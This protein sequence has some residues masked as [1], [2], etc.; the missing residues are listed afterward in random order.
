MKIKWLGHSSFLVTSEEGTKIVTDPYSVGGGISYAPINQ[1]ADVVTISHNH[2]DHNN[3]RAIKGNP[4]SIKEEGIRKAKG[5]EFKGIPSHHD[6]IQGSERGGNI[7]FCFTIDCINICHLGDLGHILDHKQIADIGSVDILLIPV[8]GYY[9]IDY[10]QATT[11]SKS[12]RPKVVIPMHYKTSK[13]GYPISKV[14]EF[15]KG[16]KNV[17]RLDLNEV[18]YKQSELP[19]QAEIVVLHHA[20]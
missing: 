14:D 1:S 16:K 19:E 20:L 7:I 13:C 3:D 10:K 2:G 12:L 8:G 5:I 4:Q 18:D 15:L 6:A 9:T 11:I 17:R